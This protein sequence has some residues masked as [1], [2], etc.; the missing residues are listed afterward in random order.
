MAKKST[1][2]RAYNVPLGKPMRYFTNG[3]VS[4]KVYYNTWQ[5][6][7]YQTTKEHTQR[8]TMKHSDYD[9]F[10]SRLFANGFK[11]AGV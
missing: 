1:S 4:I 7:V 10:E 3:S 5:N 9:N 2:G 6:E 8:I 11:L